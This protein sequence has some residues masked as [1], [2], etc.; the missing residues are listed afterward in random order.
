SPFFS[1]S[2]LSPHW[3][4]LFF[5]E[6]FEVLGPAD[7]VVAVPG[8]DV[9]LPCYLKP[10][11]SA[12]DLSVEWFRVQT[13][14]PL[15]HLYQDHEDRN[16][17]QIPSYRGRTS[18]FPEEL[19]NGNTSLKVKNVRLSDSGEYK[20]FVQSAE[21]YD[22][23]SINVQI[24]AIGTHPVISNEGYKEGGISLVCESKGWYPQPQVVWMDSEGHNLPAE[25]TETHRDSMDLFIV[26][27]R[28]I[29]QETETNRFT[30]QVLQRDLKEMKETMTEIPGEMFHHAHPWKVTFAV[31][32][33]LSAVG[34]IGGTILIHRFVKLR[35][36]RG[37]L[38]NYFDVTLDPDTAHPELVL[39]EDR[40]RVRRGV[41]WQRLPDNPERFKWWPCVLGKEGFSSGRRYWEVEVGDKTDWTLGV[42]RES[43]NRKGCF[44]LNPSGGLWALSLWNGNEYLAF[45]DPPVSLHLS[46]KPQKVGVYVDYEEGQVSFYR[47]EITDKS[48]IYTFTG[49]K[50]T[51]KLYPYFCPG[52]RKSDPLTISP[53]Q[54]GYLGSKE[55]DLGDIRKKHMVVKTQREH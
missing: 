23:Y 49:Y 36:K 42:V 6:S 47:M 38:A 16:E 30:C 26:R 43:I 13:K 40:K 50:F 53:V 17:N 22:D 21:W 55:A 10:N 8:E 15:V 19:N 18:L 28:V 4:V 24:K 20:C 51:E 45:T 32:F 5:T 29:V 9:V 2:P 37:I 35:K 7:P 33:S 52:F 48:L 3:C 54:E 46:V 11:I 27:R 41:I 14:N 34:I 12:M 31:I 39:S 44:P 25:H 1:N